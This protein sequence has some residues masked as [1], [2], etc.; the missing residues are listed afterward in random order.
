MKEISATFTSKGQLVI[1]ADL[2]RKHGITTGTKVK[3]LEDRF[4]RI[5]LQPIT[6]GYIDRV[7]GCLADGPDLVAK[8]KEEHRREGRRE[9]RKRKP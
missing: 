7:M 4:G 2:R 1:P 5:V 6:E 8:W 9:D 3:L